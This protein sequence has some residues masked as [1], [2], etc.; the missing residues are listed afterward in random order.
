[1]RVKRVAKFKKLRYKKFR[2]IFI[3]GLFL[4]S[5]LII[6]GYIISLLFIIPLINN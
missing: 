6:V 2:K 5:S 3:Y 4:P 1:M